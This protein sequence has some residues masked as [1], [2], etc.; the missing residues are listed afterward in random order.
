[1]ADNSRHDH[2]ALLLADA[3]RAL[4]GLRQSL[5]QPWQDMPQSALHALDLVSA[6]SR[7]GM[8]TQAEVVQAVSQ[9]LSLGQPNVLNLAH[10]VVQALERL[11]Q[12]RTQ[13]EL[14]SDAL[15]AAPPW[16]EWRRQVHA[17]AA[18]AQPAWSGLNASS[19]S[20]APIAG[21]GTLSAESTSTHP[22]RQQGMDLLQHARMLNARGDESA[23]RALDAVLAELQDRTCRLDQ[24]PL[25][26][27]YNQAHHRVD[28]A[29][30][31]QDIVRGLQHLQPMALRSRSIQVECRGLLLFIDW[32][33]LE[34]T[35]DERH[36][37]GKILHRLGGSLGE[38]PKGYRLCLPCSLKR[39]SGL[40]FMMA[41]R[42]YAVSAAQCPGGPLS[43]TPQADIPLNLRLGD[44]T[45]TLKTDAWLGSH[46]MNLHP[47][48][49][50]VTAPEGVKTVALDGSGRVYLWFDRLG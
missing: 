5:H 8:T 6:L 15:D 46:P 12:E 42:R 19:A 2:W 23:R 30:A 24:V 4:D 11:L 25:R 26:N 48:P 49:I 29:W 31:D 16:D 38:L 18:S 9:Q 44:Q 33:G 1:M 41:G 43:P 10:E 14:R 34:L 45:L 32:L 7:L 20:L 37:A 40:G 3:E 27:L 13:P 39:M 22:L 28:D 17:T 47:I 21:Y 50:G 36:S 35:A